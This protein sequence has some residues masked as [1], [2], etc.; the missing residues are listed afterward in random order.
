MFTRLSKKTNL[1]TSVVEFVFARPQDFNPQPGQYVNL[2]LDKVARAY[3]ISGIL[4]DSF[5]L[6]IEIIEGGRFTSLLSNLQ[7][8]D[9]IKML[10][11]IGKFTLEKIPV[12]SDLIFLATGVGIAPIKIMIESLLRETG[13]NFHSQRIRHLFLYHGL[14]FVK[15]IYYKDCFD[16]LMKENNHFHYELWLSKGKEIFGSYNIGHIQ[17]GLDKLTLSNLNSPHFFICGSKQAVNDLQEYLLQKGYSEE[18][19]HFER[20]N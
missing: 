17:D 11:P 13:I 19:I 10:G 6:T 8:G 3:S 12:D 15:D 7:I 2:V 18:S 4:E 9:E 5:S 14:R 1:T 20:F 16:K